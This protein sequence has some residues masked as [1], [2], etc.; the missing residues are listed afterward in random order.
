MMSA[1]RSGKMGNKSKQQGAGPQETRP[2]QQ[3]DRQ[4]GLQA[5]MRPQ[6]ESLNSAIAGRD[7]FAGRV[8]LVTGGDSG[9]GRAVALAF[10]REGADVAIVYLDEHED[11]RHTRAEVEKAG[12]RCVLV[13]AD[14]GE[15]TACREAVEFTVK[16]LGRLDCLVNNAAEQHEQESVEDISPEQ[17]QRTLRTNIFSMFY[18][19]A[20]AL[21]HDAEKVAGFGTDNPLGRVGRPWECAECYVFLASATASYITGQTLHPNGGEIING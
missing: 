10:A 17:L 8:A 20:A 1:N 5:G 4:P 2:P 6:P 15:P 18:L 7:L 12:R 19:T 14:I 3:Q 11:A 16:E 13:A 21:P 9:I